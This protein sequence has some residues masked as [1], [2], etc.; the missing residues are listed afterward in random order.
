[1]ETHLLIADHEMFVPLIYLSNDQQNY[2]RA[3]GFHL[4]EKVHSSHSEIGL[5][6]EFSSWEEKEKFEEIFDE[7]Y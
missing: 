4:I 1:M 5:Y 7:I 2:L 3:Y 6:K